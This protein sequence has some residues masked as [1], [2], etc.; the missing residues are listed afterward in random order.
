[1]T[2]P[3]AITILPFKPED[4][5]AVRDLILA[6]LGEHWGRIDYNLNRDLDDISMSYADALFVV[7][8]E[9]QRIVGAGAL[10][11]KSKEV[12][13]VVRMSVATDRR[14]MGVGTRILARLCTEA[15]RLGFQRITLETTASWREVVAFY[16]RFGFRVTH[17]EDSAF[18][19]EAH[20]EFDL[21]EMACGAADSAVGSDDEAD[22]IKSSVQAV[23]F[24]FDY[25][26]ADS[27]RGVV[28]CTN[29]AL[30]RLGLPTVSAEKVC[31]TIGLSL[32]DT[33]KQVAGEM[34]A[35]QSDA[36]ACLFI[37]RAD[38]VMADLTILF[39]SVPQTIAVLKK[40]GLGLGIVSTKFR[41]RIASILRREGLLD[42]FD[43]IIGGEDVPDHKPDPEGL[44]L[45]MERLGRS[46]LDCVYVGDSVVDA[47]TAA[48]A[49]VPFVA[50]LSGV[51]P[52]EAFDAYE[53]RQVLE[54]VGDLPGWVGR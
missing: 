25:T 42:A 51:T 30:A 12:A 16:Q 24:D 50:V 49:G 6:G 8:W 38:Q 22:K 21:G 3:S 36:F 31:Q 28:E 19:R 52:R 26:L 54:H 35:A 53:V 37:E 2:Q 15:K 9:G 10:V 14:R 23:I 20:F 5:A 13:E 27:S 34:T 41:Y 39:E 32:A 40:Q 11:R 33:F 18:G 1:M 44:R 17:Y 46:P 43:A 7:A 45:V 47:E 4:Q 48:R 29:F